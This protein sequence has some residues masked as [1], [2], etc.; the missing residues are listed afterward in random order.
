MDG[1][2][3]ATNDGFLHI[4]ASPLLYV[5]R[6]CASSLSPFCVLFIYHIIEGSIVVIEAFM[7]RPSKI[8]FQEAAGS[9]VIKMNVCFFRKVM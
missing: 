3:I 7:I 8:L 9:I 2:I 4:G 6:A 5:V 1:W